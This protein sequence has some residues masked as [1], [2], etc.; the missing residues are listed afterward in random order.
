M[1]LEKYKYYL[2][3]HDW[4]YD[5]APV[6]QWRIWCKNKNDLLEEAMKNQSARMFCLYSGYYHLNNNI[7]KKT[8]IR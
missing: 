2:E 5:Y 7:N 3:R 4:N 1:T 6:D 8:T